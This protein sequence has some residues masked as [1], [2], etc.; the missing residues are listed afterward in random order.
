MVLFCFSCIIMITMT[1]AITKLIS[2]VL[3][4]TRP[5][6]SHSLDYFESCFHLHQPFQ[7]YSLV[8]L[9]VP[10]QSSLSSCNSRE[11]DCKRKVRETH[12]LCKISYR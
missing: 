9:A 7:V 8:Y 10:Q 5:G 12:E 11:Y 2:P 4:E 3:R 1:L 6:L